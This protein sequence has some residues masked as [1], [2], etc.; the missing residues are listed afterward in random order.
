[1][2]KHNQYKFTKKEISLN[3]LQ[4]ENK[5]NPES[6]SMKKERKYSELLNRILFSSKSYNDKIKYKSE[7]RQNI[8]QIK[9][10]YK[11]DLKEK[12]RNIKFR[13]TNIL[14]K[15]LRKEKIIEDKKTK[16]INKNAKLTERTKTAENIKKAIKNKSIKE[17]KEI[18]KY[19]LNLK[20]ENKFSLFKFN[21]KS[22]GEHI[23]HSERTKKNNDSIKYL[24]KNMNKKQYGL[25]YD[26]AKTKNKIFDHS[27]LVQKNKTDKKK[28]NKT[29]THENINNDR[30][31]L[32][33]SHTIETKVIKRLKFQTSSQR[34]KQE[35]NILNRKKEKNYNNKLILNNSENKIL[36]ISLHTPK[37]KAKLKNKTKKEI[38]YIKLIKNDIS[39]T[40]NKELKTNGN[41]TIEDNNIDNIKKKLL[42]LANDFRNNENNKQNNQVLWKH[43][44]NLIDRIR[45]IK[46]LNNIGY[47]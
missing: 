34:N 5:K 13:K 25:K 29:K 39:L 15:E 47:A 3:V 40:E 12:K 26:K 18:I 23:I 37:D 21:N 6:Y 1:M 16:T 45:T 4:N 30:K 46:K 19:N 22:K 44:V 14:N 10:Y 9:I 7:Q 38:F 28:V 2:R 33:M 31:K 27:A 41:I 8:K 32:N 43:P 42:I 11:K 24:L 35:N 20:F 36:K 17:M